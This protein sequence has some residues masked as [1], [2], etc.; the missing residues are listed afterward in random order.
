M[1]TSGLKNTCRQKAAP[2]S[3]G[4]LLLGKICALHSLRPPCERALAWMIASQSQIQFPCWN[5]SL[6]SRWS[7]AHHSAST[8]RLRDMDA[9]LLLCL[10]R[11]QTTTA[12]G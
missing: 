6:L 12:L 8:V 9:T 1:R 3:L 4:N 5:R 10:I 11:T 2:A 7:Y